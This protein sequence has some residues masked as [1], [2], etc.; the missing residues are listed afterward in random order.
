MK[1]FLYK[2]KERIAWLVLLTVLLVLP[3]TLSLPQHSAGADSNKN[4]EKYLD[5]FLDVFSKV[6]HM[7]VDEDQTRVDTMIYGAIKGMLKSL[8][9]PHT[10]FLDTKQFKNL[11]TD[12]KG[13]FGGLGI[14][15]RI[16]DEKL[17]IINPMEGTP[18][19]EVGLKPGDHIAEIE[20]E[21]TEG[22]TI[23]E[24][25]SK[26]RGKKG[27]KVNITVIRETEPEPLSFTITRDIIQI[28][29]VE[30]EMI[31][32]TDFGYVKIRNFSQTTPADMEKVLNDIEQKDCKGLIIDLRYNPGGLLNAVIDVVDLFL[33]QGVIVYTKDRSG[34]VNH[35][36]S[37]HNGT[38]FSRYIPVI[39]LINKF[40]ASASEI[41]AGAMQDHKRALLL[42]EQTFG[43]F[44]VQNVFDIDRADK[45]AFK[46]T[47]AYYYI[48]SGRSLHEEGLPPDVKVETDTYTKNEMK[49]LKKLKSLDLIKKYVEQHPDAANDQKHLPQFMQKLASLDIHLNK[50]IIAMHIDNHRNRNNPPEL[51]DIK[52]DNQLKE[53]IRILKSN[54]IFNIK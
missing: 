22:I 51:Y 1:S 25:V 11:K 47:I 5:H 27:S 6:R 28:K 31:T 13:S 38:A 7:Y 23:E 20:G 3:F 49:M 29:S 54:K 4:N 33:D 50:K 42:G 48:P 40:S 44:S 14:Y 17:I 8:D 46:M 32:N 9:D 30:H 36:F 19:W 37:A 41:F 18:A 15:I 21:S 10:T 52:Y 45:T 16:R 43:K 39:I 34:T 2:Y 24:A 35:R 12:T 26:L 53:A